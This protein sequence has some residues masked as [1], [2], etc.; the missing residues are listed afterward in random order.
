MPEIVAPAGSLE[1]LNTAVLFGADAVYTGAEKYSLRNFNASIPLSELKQAISIAHE[2]SVKVFLALNV[3]TFDD[4]YK[5]LETYLKKAIKYGIDAIIIS[6]PGVL[7]LINNLRDQKT[8]VHLSTQ[9]N[10]TSSQAAKF[11]QT[12]G[13]SRIVLSRELN[14]AQ[15]KE[16]KKNTKGLELE[17]FV[18]GAMC[19]AYSGRCLL[20]SFL[21][22]RSANRGECTQP[23]RWPYALKEQTRPEE[24]FTVEEDGYGT[25]V[26]NSRDLCLIDYLPVLADAGVD[27]FKIEGRMKSA[28]YTAM[29]TR[30]YKDALNSYLYDKENFMVKPWWHKELDNVSHRPYTTG[31]VIP[32][33]NRE[34]SKSSAYIKHYNFSGRVLAYDQQTQTAR[35]MV[36]N[37]IRSGESMEFIDPAKTEIHQL[38]L[39]EF[40][41]ENGDIVR[42]VHNQTNILVKMPFEVSPNSLIR[43]KIKP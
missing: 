41:K 3:F 1:K 40:Q 29:V 18:H 10:V 20:S 25:Y 23:C 4:D 8:R 35:I 17:V 31:F 37:R 30:V 11:W 43:V 36:R 6:D 39:T 38:K 21:T 19:M 12:Q 14:L 9:A 5:E 28:Y 33:F 7:H 34:N 15:I 16:I 27:A 2:R 42:E 32:D 24:T 22:G 26:L 13:I